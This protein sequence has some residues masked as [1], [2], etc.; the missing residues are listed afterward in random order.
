MRLTVSLIV[1]P[2]KQ[3]VVSK[4]CVLVSTNVTLSSENFILH[5][6]PIGSRQETLRTCMQTTK[7]QRMLMLLTTNDHIVEW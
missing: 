1:I 5:F 2:T 7:H 3:M 6:F 4:E